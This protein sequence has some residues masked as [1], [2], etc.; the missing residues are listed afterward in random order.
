MGG[1]PEETIQRIRAIV[2]LHGRY[3]LDAYV[4]LLEALSYALEQVRKSGRTGH[5]D[6]RELLVHLRAHARERFGWLART[7]FEQWGVKTTADFGEIVFQ[8]AEADL[9]SRQDSDKLEDFRDV[10]D[11]A[12]LEEKFL[13]D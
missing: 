11:F 8:L 5:I 10:F 3:A 7:V 2:R 12:E 4:F 1:G 9:L 6:G 13:D